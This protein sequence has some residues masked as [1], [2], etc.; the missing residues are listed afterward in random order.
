[1]SRASRRRAHGITDEET[2]GALA[3]QVATSS[4]RGFFILGAAASTNP[5]LKPIEEGIIRAGTNAGLEVSAALVQLVAKL[6]PDL[7]AKAFA[8]SFQ[9][10]VELGSFADTHAAT[11]ALKKREKP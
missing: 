3:A 5:L 9:S 8:E 7:D 1:M 2:I 4:A 10:H 11:E 6:R